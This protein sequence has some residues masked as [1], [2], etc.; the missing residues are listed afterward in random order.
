MRE[1]IY[2]KD[3]ID[4]GRSGM[5]RNCNFQHH[6]N[7]LREVDL[8][9]IEE[10]EPPPIDDI[11]GIPIYDKIDLDGVPLHSFKEDLDGMPSKSYFKFVKVPSSQKI[12]QTIVG[13][14]LLVSFNTEF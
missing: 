5:C 12:W 8:P 9:V 7:E 4:N 14:L 6:D 2:L 11:D 10:R 1:C 13:Q 3:S